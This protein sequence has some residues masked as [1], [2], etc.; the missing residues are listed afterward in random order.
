MQIDTSTVGG[1][2]L[3]L[4]A[5]GGVLAAIAKGME[6]FYRRQTEREK[7]LIDRQR[8]DIERERAEVVEEKQVVDQYRKLTEDLGR[9]VDILRGQYQEVWDLHK[10]CERERLDDARL[11]AAERSKLERRIHELEVRIGVIPPPPFTN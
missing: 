10:Q 3:F 11:H 4:L 5:N 8:A 6:S 7:A 2:L 9:S 1:A